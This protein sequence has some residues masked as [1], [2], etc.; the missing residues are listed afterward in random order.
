MPTSRAFQGPNPRL[1][2]PVKCHRV[3]V[4]VCGT[5]SLGQR[6]GR[7]ATDDMARAAV[8]TDT[9]VPRHLTS[10]DGSE[11][12]DRASPA[13]SRE[14]W[15]NWMA[16][17]TL[18]ILEL[19]ICANY[20]AINVLFST[21]C[22][23]F[24]CAK[25]SDLPQDL[26]SGMVSGEWSLVSGHRWEVSGGAPPPSTG[27]IRSLIFDRQPISN[28]HFYGHVQNE[29]ANKWLT[30]KGQC[31]RVYFGSIGFISSLN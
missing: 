24:D 1:A 22:L 9:P 8:A 17:R 2:A 10:R 31:S 14:S 29:R 27:L 28:G 12:S 4:C 26:L 20:K 21:F 16:T 6:H 7:G 25:N 3:C 30:E 19:W 13:I 11:P 15:I 23:A 18:K 5:G